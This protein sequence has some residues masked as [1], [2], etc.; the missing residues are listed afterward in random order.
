MTESVKEE[1]FDWRDTNLWMIGSDLDHEIKKAAAE[2]EPQW[3][4][5]GQQVE[6]KIWRIEKF[7]VKSWPETKWG[8]FHIGDSYIILNTYK[9][10]PDNEKLA[11]DVHF[12]IGKESSQDEYGTAAYKTVE[13]DEVLNCAAIQH[14][15]IQGQESKLFRSY[16]DN[17]KYLKGGVASG[18]RHVEEEVHVV[19]MYQIKGSDGDFMIVELELT[20][21]SMNEGDVFVL[22]AGDVIY[23]WNGKSASIGEKRKANEVCNRKRTENREEAKLVV[24]E[25][26][27]EDEEFWK[28]LPEKTRSFLFFSTSH[29]IKSADE[30]GVDT[31]VESFKPI[32]FEL[33]DTSGKLKLKQASKSHEVEGKFK[34]PRDCLESDDVFIL[35][36]G[37]RIFVYI[38]Q[39][40]S[41][42]EK[43][44]AFGYANKYLSEYK[45]PGL[46]PVT[47]L[48]HNQV[49]RDFEALLYDRPNPGCSCTIL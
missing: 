46:L 30:G 17:L 43:A 31:E 33:S 35:D 47:V 12:W 32:L 27:Q 5:I 8:Q 18:F 29:T 7:I 26:G 23:Q 3:K 45:R 22:D 6:L 39:D 11:Y 24:Q 48:R 1:G 21:N 14:R 49:L 40:A 42:K 38:G 20:R 16:F 2:T 41:R 9:P 13:C 28:Y 15:E 34:I 19:K 37:Y 44:G 4:G 10:D 25:Q 36:G